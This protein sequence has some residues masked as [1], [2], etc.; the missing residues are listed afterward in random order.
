MANWVSSGAMPA[1]RR[2][3]RPARSRVLAL[4]GAYYLVTGIAPF[5]SRRWF[6]RVTGPKTEWWLVQTA[7]AMIGVAGAGLTSAAI[8]ERTTP[9]VVGMAAGW[10]ASLALIDVAFV[11][12]GRIAPTYLLDASV[13][14]AL[15]AALA[16][17]NAD[18]ARPRDSWQ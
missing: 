5:M 17:G 1:F 12:R 9:E 11:A 10:A 6:E 16:I 7:G 15:L 18:G 4:Q 8:R 3:A 13:E 14:V 2:F